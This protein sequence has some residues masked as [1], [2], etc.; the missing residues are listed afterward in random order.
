M[1]TEVWKETLGER[2]GNKDGQGRIREQI[3]LNTGIGNVPF[4]QRHE[5]RDG[6][7]GE[8]YF[9]YREQQEHKS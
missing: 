8:E 6:L 5:G 3:R 7:H 9:R 4:E 1:E 2:G